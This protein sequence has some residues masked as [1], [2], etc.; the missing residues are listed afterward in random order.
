MRRIR[1]IVLGLLLEAGAS[2]S[3]A[4]LSQASRK[5]RSKLVARNLG[6]SYGWRMVHC[7]LPG[8]FGQ[9]GGPRPK[10]E[11]CG[12]LVEATKLIPVD[13]REDGLRGIPRVAIRN[14]VITK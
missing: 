1:T 14:K 10:Q 8:D 4:L 7:R 11:A 13:K 5:S 9:V 2:Q 6:Q 3:F 12:S